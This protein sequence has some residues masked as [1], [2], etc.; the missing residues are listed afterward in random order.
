MFPLASI[1]RFQV[2]Q[3]KSKKETGLRIRKAPKQWIVFHDSPRAFRALE[4]SD[5]VFK[6]R[7]HQESPSI[8]TVGSKSV[9]SNQQTSAAGAPRHD[10]QSQKV[11]YQIPQVKL[12]SDFCQF[13]SSLKEVCFFFSS[14]NLLTKLPIAFPHD[15]YL[16]RVKVMRSGVAWF[17]KQEA[18]ISIFLFHLFVQ[19]F[20]LVLFVRVILSVSGLL[21]LVVVVKKEK[22]C[23]PFSVFTYE[24]I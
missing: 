21:L 8:R 12:E 13:S 16:T 24:Y 19:S 9:T 3:T 6:Q 7:Q 17:A 4:L 18:P 2:L 14:L 22:R 5:F 11:Y 10:F 20:M 15:G 1:N 23:V